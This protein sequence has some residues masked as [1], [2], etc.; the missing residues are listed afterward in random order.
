MRVALVYFVSMGP[1]HIF[2]ERSCFKL[3]DNINLSRKNVSVQWVQAWMKERKQWPR[4]IHPQRE[5]NALSRG[6]RYVLLETVRMTSRGNILP[7]R[8]FQL[9]VAATQR[10]RQLLVD[11]AALAIS[12][13]VTPDS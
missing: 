8:S 2:L 11:S 7:F 5:R 9:A 13:P 3:H 6:G 12:R 10:Q 1:F 4:S